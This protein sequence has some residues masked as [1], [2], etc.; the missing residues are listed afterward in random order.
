MLRFVLLFALY[1]I[2]FTFSLELPAADRLI[3]PWTRANAPAAV[4]G[5]RV[6][7]FDAHAAGVMM[8]AGGASLSV[9]H[10]CDGIN[11]LLIFA[12]AVLAFPAPWTRRLIGLAAGASIIFGFNIIRLINLLYVAARFPDRLELFHIY[13]WQTLIILLA[14]GTFLLWGALLAGKR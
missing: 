12:S 4:A 14:F 7:G 13:I 2:V 3:D 8:S 10:G 11:A 5:I 6:M 9:A 1:L